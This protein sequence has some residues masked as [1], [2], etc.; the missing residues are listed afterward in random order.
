MV[1]RL[2]RVLTSVVLVPLVA[3]HVFAAN[4]CDRAC[5]KNAPDQDER[6]CSWFDKLT[7]SEN[8]QAFW[9]HHTTS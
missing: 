4:D 8:V 6:S 3:S 1:S 9:T 7:T 5:L 2:V